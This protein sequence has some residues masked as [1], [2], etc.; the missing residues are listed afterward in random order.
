[1]LIRKA[2]PADK[3]ELKKLWSIVFQ[4][5]PGFLETF[6]ARRFA[7][8]NI[9]LAEVDGAIVSA[10]HAPPVKFLTTEGTRIDAVYVVGAATLAEH[11]KRGYMEALLSAVKQE[12]KVPVLLYPAV[13]RYYEKNG[14]SSCSSTKVYDLTQPHAQ[15]DI[16]TPSRTELP[17]R[18]Q[19]SDSELIGKL[20]TAYETSIT[21]QGG[22]LR[23]AIAWEFLLEEYYSEMSFI[24]DDEYGVAYA[25]VRN[26]QAVETAAQ[27]VEAGKLLLEQLI[28]RHEGRQ[29]TGLRAIGGSP[30]DRVLTALGMQYTP[31]EEGMSFPYIENNPYIGEQY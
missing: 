30:L 25:F 18:S 4:E 13:R 9:F 15:L 11:R 23:D 16:A 3:D 17:P 29:V 22:L 27:S 21:V 1:M 10:L 26:G 6:F 24:E 7:P 2:T 8:E 5:E 28:N 31:F 14:F 20:N 19:K 12:S